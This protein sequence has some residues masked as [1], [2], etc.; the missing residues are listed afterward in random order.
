MKFRIHPV[1]LLGLLVL[2][3]GC[4]KSNE[5]AT[6]TSP[7]LPLNKFDDP[8]LVRIYDLAD[9]RLG[10]SLLPFL[11]HESP[12]YRL[13]AAQVMGSVQ[14]TNAGK[15]L[16]GLLDDPSG[17]ISQAAAWAIGQIGDSSLAD[18]LWAKFK[19]EKKDANQV[20]IAEALGKTSSKS[21]IQGIF[22]EA[23][24]LPPTA[25]QRTA[26]M[27]MLYRAGLRKIVP[28]S[29]AVFA[30]ECLSPD[31]PTAQLHAAAFLG[32]VPESGPIQNPVLLIDRFHQ[33]VDDEVKQHLVK[34]LRRCDAPECT[35]ELRAIMLDTRQA[36]AT[37]VNA[38]RAA[39]NVHPIAEEANKAV[40]DPNQQV[41]VTAAEHIRDNVKQDF[42]I[43][44]ATCRKVKAW[45]PRAILLSA[46]MADAIG[47][48]NTAGKAKIVAY[49]DS[50]SNNAQA[51]EKGAIF[52]ALGQDQAQHE[53]LL[54]KAL[55]LEKV[56]S[57]YAT[58]A[59]VAYH[60]K[61]NSDDN[62]L[63]ISQ[64]QQLLR[65]GD[66]GLIAMTAEHL[67]GESATSKIIQ[68]QLKDVLFLDSALRNLTL[69]ADIE[70]YNA[71][72]K[73]IAA[74]QKKEFKPTKLEHEFPIDW[75]LVKRIPTAQTAEI[76]TTKGTIVI[77]LKVEDTPGSVANFVKLV[78][79][80]FYEGNSFHRVV[81]AFVAQGGC[82]RGDGW[83]SSPE[84]IRSEWPALHYS[85]GQVGMASAGKDTESCQWF[86]TH[87]DIPHLDG[88]YTIFASVISGME[89]VDL[90]EIGDRIDKITL[91]GL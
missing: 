4:S 3:I 5:T 43:T 53:R 68:T 28:D 81:P 13:A 12:R 20:R 58:E 26:L 63:W 91:P 37:R 72:E 46:A 60:D 67:A 82:P 21:Q 14:D 75:A 39:G 38:I 83:G 59:L 54:T 79:K 56:T 57:T 33:S 74:I 89:V 2:A 42:E 47:Q 86:I 15:A 51:Y 80:G 70:A 76:H 40:L 25:A 19:A 6:V 90:L 7:P 66:P 27:H 35:Q 50:L 55:Q 16:L 41:A 48:R 65:T 8:V 73:A 31:F 64:L 30:M 36:T 1:F 44:L 24:A 9:R 10:D 29:A 11:S 88:R 22:K 78:Q 71:V 61:N 77:Q 32:R 69:P 84:T 23:R 45:R 85:R 18:G 34:A 87:N 52:L 62:K 17:E 49:A